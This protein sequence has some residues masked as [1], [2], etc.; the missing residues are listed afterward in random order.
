MM[1]T[2]TKPALAGVLD[3]AKVFHKRFDSLLMSTVSRDGDPV[4]SYAPYVTDDKGCFFIYVSELSAHTANLM[5]YQKASVLFIEDENQARHLFGRQRITYTCRAVAIK[6]DSSAFD[7]A[8]G[9]FEYKHGKFMAMMRSLRDFHLFRL[10]PDQASF[11]RGFAE[12]FELF[13][14]GLNEIRHVNDKGH[15]PGNTN[16]AREM[17]NLAQ[18]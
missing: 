9:A 3:E 16:V 6:R 2:Q 12:A 4:A 14:E 18:A 15:R 5:H 1:Q 13:G 7:D 17:N 10:M 8:M 11:V